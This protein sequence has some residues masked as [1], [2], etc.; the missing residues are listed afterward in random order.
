MRFGSYVCRVTEGVQ[1]QN[2]VMCLIC[3][4]TVATIVVYMIPDLRR[5]YREYWS[6][7]NG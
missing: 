5:M 3:A 7:V 2:F 4:A 6:E 1:M